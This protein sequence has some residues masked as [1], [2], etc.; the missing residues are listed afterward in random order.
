VTAPQLTTRERSAAVLV[1]ELHVLTETTHKGL[2]EATI[3]GSGP[4]DFE[5]AETLSR[6]LKRA[7]AALGFDAPLAR[8]LLSLRELLDSHLLTASTLASCKLD[9]CSALN[10]VRR[11]VDAV[12][13]GLPPLDDPILAEAPVTR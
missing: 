6:Q 5:D 13:A 2:W 4:V 3:A 7:G 10:M 11:G 12:A 9:D 8:R 1:R